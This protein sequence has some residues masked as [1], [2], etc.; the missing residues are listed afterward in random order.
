MSLP[1]FPGLTAAEQDQVIAA[2]RAS[3]GH[4][5]TEAVAGK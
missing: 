1:M 2:L 3:I 4:H 5:A